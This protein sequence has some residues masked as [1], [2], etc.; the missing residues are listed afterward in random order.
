MEG[1]YNPY[2]PKKLP[3]KKLPK[4]KRLKE[5]ATSGS[6]NK[7][8]K[9]TGPTPTPAP[10]S[11]P[12]PPTATATATAPATAP[13]T[14]PLSEREKQILKNQLNIKGRDLSVDGPRTTE[15][16]KEGLQKTYEERDFTELNRKKAK[17]ELR[18][19]ELKLAR[20]RFKDNGIIKTFLEDVISSPGISYLCYKNME[21]IWTKY[22]WYIWENV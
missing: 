17:E 15:Q 1:Q 7:E 6:Q 14:S 9:T 22:F 5:V 18:I 3:P 4:R 2:A 13:A 21:S 10:A 20:I 8:A 19:R 11:A 12:A 16:I